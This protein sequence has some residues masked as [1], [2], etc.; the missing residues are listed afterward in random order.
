MMYRATRSFVCPWTGQLYLRGKL[1][2]IQDADRA[3]HLERHG[4]IERVDKA[5][6]GDEP[7]GANVSRAESEP[8]HVGGGRYEPSEGRRARGKE[9]A[10]QEMRDGAGGWCKTGDAHR[11]RDS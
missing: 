6:A 7:A 3:A 4:R 9:L 5:P 11:L 10:L 8:K 1:C 2:L